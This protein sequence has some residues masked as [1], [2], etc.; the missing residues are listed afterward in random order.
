MKEIE[1]AIRLLDT[2]TIAAVKGKRI[3]TSGKRGISALLEYANAGL[4]EGAS[5]ADKIVG[6]AAALLMAAGG[7]KRVFGGVMTGEAQS[8]LDQYNI[9]YSCN[10]LADKILNRDK[11]D[12]CPIERAVLNI[13]DP[14]GAREVI[15]ATL[16][17]LRNKQNQARENGKM[18][19]IDFKSFDNAKLACFVWDKADKPKAVIQILHGMTSHMKRYDE[20][21]KTLNGYGYI[22]FGDDH[23][24]NGESAGLEN[25]GKADKT[26]FFQN[27]RDEIEITKMLKQKYNLPILLFA[28]SYGSFLAQS[29][30][31]QA[32]ELVDGVI[33]SGSSIM[34]KAKLAFGV[35]LTFIQKGYLK[36]DEPNMLLYNMT[37]ASNNKPFASENLVNAWLNRDVDK[38]KK[39]ND[40]PYCNF[41]MS[42]GFYY[43][44]MRGLYKTFSTSEIAKIRKDLPIFIISGEFD[45]LGGMGKKVTK[46]YETY[47]A[48]G[49]NV[50]FK[51]YKGARHELTSDT[52][53]DMVIRDMIEF[54]ERC[55]NAGNK[56]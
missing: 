12:L 8:I 13:S 20:L 14:F 3:I 25:L 1:K 30:I 32:G 7:A 23:R 36:M 50:K 51:L 4:L 54:F 33:L 42:H 16:K 21:G 41:Y 24:P 47:K 10:I 53:K 22:V 31:A 46:L 52:E 27:V 28:H 48:Q 18:E 40:D 49:L 34:S 11:T 17:E 26:N 15:A 55:I 5:V 2:N 56:A 9:P 35:L 38:V 39:F 19:K 45:P 44:M 29:Y 6:K 37:F 43:S